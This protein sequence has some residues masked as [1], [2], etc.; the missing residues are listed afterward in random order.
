MEKYHS[1]VTPTCILVCCQGIFYAYS[2]CIPGI[3]YAYVNFVPNIS[4]TYANCGINISD[5]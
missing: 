2:N 3:F 5:F 1:S 4:F